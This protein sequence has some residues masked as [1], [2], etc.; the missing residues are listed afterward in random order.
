MNINE[1]AKLAGVSRATVSRYLNNGYVSREKKI[2][3]AR[4][5]EATGY[6]PSSQA[7]MLRSRR[8]NVIG[9]IIPR[10]NSDA[11]S[12]EMMGISNVLAK[13]NYQFLLANTAN[14]ERKELDYIKVFQNNQVDGIILIATI[15]TPEHRKLLKESNVPVVIVGQNVRGFCSVYH[16]D[17]SAAKEITGMLISEGRTNIGYMGVSLRDEAAGAGRYHGYMD[18]FAEHGIRMNERAMVEAAFSLEDGYSKAKELFWRFP[19]LD[20]LFC[21]TD[22]IAIGAMEYL[23]ES[24]KKIPGDISVVGVGHTS[25]S[26]VVSPKLTTVHFYY[27]TAGEEAAGLLMQMVKGEESQRR[28]IKMGYEIVKRGSTR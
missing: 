4:V 15:F 20:G 2:A 27:E 1:I 7:R 17:Y 26:K 14:N 21:A 24:G 3:I 10:L 5:I 25:L 8:T 13:E 28:D 11:V 6:I 18:A 19:E 16:D 22:S 12:R 9:V 23:K